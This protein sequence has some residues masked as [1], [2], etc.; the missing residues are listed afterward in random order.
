MVSA[1]K[2]KPRDI[3]REN[4]N[5]YDCFRHIFYGCCLGITK[6]RWSNPEWLRVKSTG[7]KQQHGTNL[8][9]LYMINMRSLLT[10][11]WYSIRCISLIFFLH[12]FMLRTDISDRQDTSGRFLAEWNRHSWD[13]LYLISTMKCEGYAV[14]LFKMCFIWLTRDD[15]IL[16]HCVMRLNV[17]DK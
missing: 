13:I 11:L 14:I 5:P 12:H 17:W 16:I 7:V 4:V 3:L 10:L 9:I 8:L 1:A 2:R 6:C 15:G